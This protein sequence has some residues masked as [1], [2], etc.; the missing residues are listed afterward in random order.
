MLSTMS[1]KAADPNLRGALIET[2]ARLLAEHGPDAVSLRRLANEVGT[3]T[4]AIYTHFGSMGELRLALRDEGFARLAARMNAVDETGDTVADLIGLSRAYVSTARTAP[5]LYRAMFLDGPVA[6]GDDAVKGLG[7]F[8]HLVH[9][10]TRCVDAGR[11]DADDPEQMALQLWS[12]NHGVLMLHFAGLINAE[13]LVTT[14]QTGGHHLLQGFGDDPRAIGRSAVAA[15][16][17]AA[18]E[19][20]TSS[21]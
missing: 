6:G 14:L 18:T 9:G 8:K 13:Q 12:F 3:S 10:V 17:R 5:N 7:T 4:M 19:V 2:A 11:F 1:P 16:T 15:Q 20:V 21:G